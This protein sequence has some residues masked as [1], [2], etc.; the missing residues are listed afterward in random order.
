LHRQFLD[1]DHP[2][3][4]D[5]E[6]FTRGRTIEHSA[7]PELTGLQ[8]RNQLDA[9]KPDPER[10]GY[11]LGY[12]EQHS[13]THKPSLW[14][15]PYFHQLKLPHNIDVMHTEKNVAEIIFSTM[16]DIAEK[17]KDNVKARVDQELLCD[18]PKLKMQ[19]PKGGK[20]WRKPKASF[21]LTRD[22]RREIL[23]WF[24]TLMFPDGYA[25]NLKRAA[26]L[27]TL[28][29]NGMKSHDWHI[30]LERILPVMIRGYIPEE[31]WLVLAELSYFFR[32][33]CAKELSVQVVKD[34]EKLVPVLLC[35]L[36]MIFPPGLFVPM[37]HL[38]IHLPSEALLN[39]TVQPRW[40]YGPE[41]MMKKLR[42]KCKNKAKIEPS[43]AQVFLYEEVTNFTTSYYNENIPTMHNPV[44]RYNIGDPERES[45]LSLFKGQLGP[46]GA[47]GSKLSIEEWRTITLYIFYNL[48]E[49]RPYIE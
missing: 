27:D 43:M 5:T 21:V 28:R 16:F 18:R 36:E 40:C 6:K 24:K 13:W 20:N 33:L 3:R 14:D 32:V 48:V 8:I 35:K 10:P 25:A 44:S 29:L 39:G 34:M 38:I 42:E 11:Y 31:D 37:M 49:M 1:P 15:L 46:A 12:G 26:N 4:Q 41:R 17:T 22:Q 23:L 9:L 45:K 47:S 7:P 19:P 30:W 2:F